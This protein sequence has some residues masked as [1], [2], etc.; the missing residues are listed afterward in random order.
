[1]F[2]GNQIIVVDFRQW[3]RYGYEII[4][5]GYVMPVWS[6]INFAVYFLMIVVF[7]KSGITS[8]TQV[9]L[10][11]IIKVSTPLQRQKVNVFSDDV[12]I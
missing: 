4:L 12:Y 1:V 11:E 8:T 9:C 10:V 7:L 2:V 3:Y 6:V 5:Y